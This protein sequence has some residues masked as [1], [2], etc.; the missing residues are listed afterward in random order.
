MSP[1]PKVPWARW[2]NWALALVV[3]T[4]VLTIVAT[5]YDIL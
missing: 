5:L 2:S 4:S 1:S 3:L